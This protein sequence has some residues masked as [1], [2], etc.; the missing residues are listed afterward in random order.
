MRRIACLVLPLV[1]ALATPAGASSLPDAGL[2][3]HK[4]VV[5]AGILDGSVDFAVT[6]RL[7]LGAGSVW[8]L[9]AGANYGRATYRVLDTTWLGD[10]A[11]NLSAGTIV[12]TL[13]KTPPGQFVFIGPVFSRPL[14]S[15][16]VLRGSLG[17]LLSN[18]INIVYGAGPS[19]IEGAGQEI[20]SRSWGLGL[21]GG[22][23]AI[24]YLVP[25]LE[26]AF[27][28]GEHHDLTLGGNSVIGWRGRF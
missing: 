12:G 2:K 8:N 27:P 4:L 7:Q 20:L 9:L 24:D 18:N 22:P 19:A 6:D 28:F 5:T 15:I 23:G 3:G 14:G 13:A 11:L 17:L 10:I 21:G 16:A 26:L 1:L 25:N